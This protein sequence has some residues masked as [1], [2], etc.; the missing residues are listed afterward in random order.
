MDKGLESAIVTLISHD[1]K[2]DKQREVIQHP[3]RGR[4]IATIFSSLDCK[5]MQ[6]P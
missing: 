4:D 6:N 3:M 1:R 5:E 2:N